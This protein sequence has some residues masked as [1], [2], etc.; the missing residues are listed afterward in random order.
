MLYTYN[1]ASRKK[2]QTKA[3]KTYQF[4]VDLINKL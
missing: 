4:I 2:L 3:P 1:D